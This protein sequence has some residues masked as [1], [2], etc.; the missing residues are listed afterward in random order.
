MDSTTNTPASDRLRL[1]DRVV[2][3][4]PRRRTAL[5]WVHWTMVPLI[6]WFVIVTPEVALAMGGQTAFLI[7]SNLALF[8]V[9]LSL[10]WTADYLRRGLASRPG[11]KLPPWARR[12]HRWIHLSLVWGLFFVALTGFLLGLTST[13]QLRA[14]GFLPFAPP[15]GLPPA[16]KVV[17]TIHIYQFYLL[18]AV[19]VGHAAFHIWRHLRLRDNALRIMVPKRLHRFL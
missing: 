16:N 18:A 8:F 1:R 6:I 12:V 11:P 9:T 19:V 17:G 2:A 10:L 13:V 3:R 14:G 5:K 15:L 7:H 4:L